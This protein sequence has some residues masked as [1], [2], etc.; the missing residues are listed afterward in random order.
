LPYH[1]D[2]ECGYRLTCHDGTN[3]P[4]DIRKEIVRRE[5]RLDFARVYMAVH[6][7]AHCATTHN[8][9]FKSA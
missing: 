8:P 9:E 2:V 4:D 1:H 7:Y 3:L 6:G 5:A